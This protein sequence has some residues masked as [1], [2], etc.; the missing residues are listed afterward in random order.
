MW[1][2]VAVMAV[3]GFVG[4]PAQAKEPSVKPSTGDS[5]L[6]ERGPRRGGRRHYGPRP[7]RG[8]R[9]GGFYFGGYYG[10]RYRPFYGPRI[11]V[12]PSPVIVYGGD[13]VCCY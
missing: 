7:W 11:I 2:L 8:P 13:S 5:T 10:P 1:V 9:G 4:A 12:A 6:I 3:L